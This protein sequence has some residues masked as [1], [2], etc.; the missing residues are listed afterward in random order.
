MRG[1]STIAAV[2]DPQFQ[3]DNQYLQPGSIPTSTPPASHT[4]GRQAP[5]GAIQYNCVTNVKDQGFA[6]PD[7]SG[8]MTSVDYNKDPGGATG[9]QVL[10]GAAT[11]P[12]HCF[13]SFDD[14]LHLAG[15]RRLA[16]KK[17]AQAP[18]NQGGTL[19]MVEVPKLSLGVVET[20]DSLLNNVIYWLRVQRKYLSVI[21][22]DIG[23]VDRH[24]QPGSKC[25]FISICFVDRLLMNNLNDS[26]L[27]TCYL[28]EPSGV[29]IR[30]KSS[31]PSANL[32]ISYV[33]ANG[34]KADISRK[35]VLTLTGNNL[36][37]SQDGLRPN[38]ACLIYNSVFNRGTIPQTFKQGILCLLLSPSRIMC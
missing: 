22:A 34:R 13:E 29:G 31:P 20:L 3:A 26:E 23:E 38:K 2:S 11:S 19:F 28:R 24:C 33:D 32:P 21:R 37:L 1:T 8:K 17:Q 9:F 4:E 5:P 16:L 18:G 6:R 14:A 36:Q 25:D 35:C 30:L 7:R 10:S 27:C 15:M 12:N